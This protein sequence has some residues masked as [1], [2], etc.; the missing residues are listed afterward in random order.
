MYAHTQAHVH[1]YTTQI[2]KTSVTEENKG[3][4]QKFTVIIVKCVTS[5]FDVFP[6]L[7]PGEAHV[8]EDYSSAVCD[9]VTLTTCTTV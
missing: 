3:L 7:N 9:T 6:F 1:T 4:I 8:R 2:N 5:N